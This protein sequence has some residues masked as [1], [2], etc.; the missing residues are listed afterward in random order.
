MTNDICLKEVAS[1]FRA[2]GFNQEQIGMV[3]G[4]IVEHRQHADRQGF[5]RGFENG[6]NHAMDKGLCQFEDY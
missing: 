5:T 4:E 1:K 3:I 6:F 2:L